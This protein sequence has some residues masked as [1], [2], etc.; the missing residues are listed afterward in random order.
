VNE[1]NASI[2]SNLSAANANLTNNI[3]AQLQALQSQLKGLAMAVNARPVQPAPPAAAQV[4]FQMPYQPPQA[5]QYPTVYQ[6]AYQ[7]PYQH[8][9]GRA[10]RGEGRRGGRYGGRYGGHSNCNGGQSNS[11][12]QQ[13]QFAGYQQQ[14]PRGNQ[15]INPVKRHK[16][17]NYCWSHGHDV[18]EWHTSQTCPPASQ[19]PGHMH[20]A[21]R[22]NHCGGSMKGIH[23]MQM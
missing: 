8:T 2:F 5:P 14:G 1:H 19:K 7:Q 12:Q 15:P 6:P 9:G 18:E 22:Y 21:T 17:W 4:P 20:H 16:N 13:G 11:Y 23:K 10:G 3:G